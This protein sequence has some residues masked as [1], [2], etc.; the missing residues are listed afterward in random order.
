MTVFYMFLFS[1]SLFPEI[2]NLD[3]SIEL[4]ALLFAVLIFSLLVKNGLLDY[5]IRGLVVK[6]KRK[7]TSI[8]IVYLAVTSLTI[9]SFVTKTQSNNAFHY[10]FVT[11]GMLIVYFVIRFANSVEIILQSKI[12]YSIVGIGFIVALIGLIQ[13]AMGTPI[14]STFGRTSYLGCFLAVN[15]AVALGML[16]NIQHSTR[17]KQ[18]RSENEIPRLPIIKGGVLI[19]FA[20]ILGVTILTKSRTAMIALAVVLPIIVL[21]CKSEKVRRWKSQY[22]NRITGYPRMRGARGLWTTII[23]RALVAIFILIALFF[24]GKI[25]YKL[26]PMSASGRVLIWKVSA[27]MVKKNPISGVGFGNF[28]NQYNLYQADYFASGKGSVINKMTAGQVRHA[29]N[30]YLETAAEFGS[31]GLIVF[32]IFWWLILMEIYKVFVP[33]RS[34]STPPRQGGELTGHGSRAS[35]YVTLGMAGAVLCFMIMSLF[36]FPRM[37]I[38]TYLLFNIALAW[39][40]NANL[41]TQKSQ[42]TQNEVLATNC[43]N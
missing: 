7:F 33:P 5:R 24:G 30:W 11:V 21:K 8:D 15:A 40:V 6:L 12:I 34:P 1:I 2:V 20:V 19:A 39:I 17:N 16:L 10:V 23:I 18:C 28:A 13:F 27:E 3:F 38:P 42:E 26:K 14:V 9:I 36:Q 43:T 35:D 31:F 37:I 41:E 25:A 22:I 32:G 4:R 29:Y